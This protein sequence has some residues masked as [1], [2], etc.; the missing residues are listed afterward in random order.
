M[1][2]RSMSR[3][4][5]KHFGSMKAIQRADETTLSNV[6]GVGTERAAT[7]IAEM[8]ELEDVITR[9]EQQGVNL[10][11][12][13]APQGKPGVATNGGA[14]LAGKTLVVTGSMTGKLE[15]LNRNAVH[16]LIEAAGGKTS[17][18][19]TAKTSYLVTGDAAGSKL[20][21]ATELGVTIISPDQLCDLINYQS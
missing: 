10:V 3:R 9:L 13:V 14:A 8:R 6:E 1:T 4:L 2:G 12:D 17:S 11:E 21:K 16:E 20:K 19:V 15:T 18:S 7:I 5:A